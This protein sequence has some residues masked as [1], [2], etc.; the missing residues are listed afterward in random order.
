[1]ASKS[2]KKSRKTRSVSGPLLLIVAAG[3]IAFAIYYIYFLKN[4]KLSDKEEVIGI[5]RGVGMSALADTLDAH[6]LI[7]SR[8]AFA[9]AGRTLG[10]AKKLHAGMYRV[11]P[12]LSNSEII[13]RLTGSEFALIMQ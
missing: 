12:G 2:K 11:A 3:V 6:H 8:W 10:T 7:R 1:M 4:P 9:I 5:H 13:R